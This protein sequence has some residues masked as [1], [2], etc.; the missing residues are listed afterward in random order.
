MKTNI[1]LFFDAIQKNDFKT[2]TSDRIYILSDLFHKAV[3][4]YED[5]L[6]FKDFYDRLG[7]IFIDKK[8]SNLLNTVKF[9][10]IPILNNKIQLYAEY[11]IYSMITDVYN[12]LNASYTTFGIFCSDVTSL[13]NRLINKKIMDF[14]NWLEIYFSPH[15]LIEDLNSKDKLSSNDF[16]LIANLNLDEYSNYVYKNFVS[17]RN[18]IEKKSAAL[19][20]LFLL[21]D[22]K[23]DL[24]L[25]KIAISEDVLDEQRNL[26]I[27][28]L[29]ARKISDLTFWKK[30]G[31]Y[32]LEPN[33][34]KGVDL[35]LDFLQISSRNDIDTLFLA[36][37]VSDDPDYIKILLNIVNSFLTK[38]YIP[39]TFQKIF[40]LLF[41]NYN[42]EYCDIF[43]KTLISKYSISELASKVLLNFCLNNDDYKIIGDIYFVRGMKRIKSNKEVYSNFIYFLNKIM[44]QKEIEEI[45]ERA[46]RRYQKIDGKMNFLF[47]LND[48]F[49]LSK[50]NY[51]SKTGKVWFT[52][53]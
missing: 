13:Q 14:K 11:K 49:P 17:R 31:D 6:I 3:L 5:F 10:N 29:F 16:E 21:K 9:Q 4:N 22:K 27:K 50:I 52:K 48:F 46:L 28:N 39:Y 47:K 34:K 8:N 36:E 40:D 1:E 7:D 2:I 18:S 24:Y 30:I 45:I 26:I 12:F 32:N 53:R 37:I 51:S 35:I 42:E 41:S 33:V 15:K 20:T 23:S 19:E 25:K 38:I 43:T 44:R